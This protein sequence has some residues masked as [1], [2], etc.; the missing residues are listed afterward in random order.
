[1]NL[2]LLQSI[3]LESLSLAAGA[4]KIS[5]RRILIMITFTVMGIRYFQ[6]RYK[7]RKVT[8]EEE[9]VW[10]EAQYKKDENGLYPWEADTD[11][12]PERVTPDSK[13]MINSWGP[14]RGRWR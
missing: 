1:M 5:F 2:F 6:L 11:D 9:N 13:P 8:A 14:K 7:R 3:C 12:S 4:G 10:I